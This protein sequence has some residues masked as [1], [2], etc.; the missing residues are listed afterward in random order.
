M[1]SHTRLD[2]RG[3]SQEGHSREPD[4]PTAARLPQPHLLSRVVIA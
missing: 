1:R 2:S 4:G 3:E